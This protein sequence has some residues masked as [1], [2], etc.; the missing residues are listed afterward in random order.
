MYLFGAFFLRLEAMIEI[1]GNQRKKKGKK[2]T[3][4]LVE[5]IFNF[6]CQKKQFFRIVEMYFSMNAS[7]RV[8][9]TYFLASTNH[10]LFFV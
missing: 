2:N 7:F 9:E 3:F 10:K 6:F 1:M 4:V 5:T 8:V